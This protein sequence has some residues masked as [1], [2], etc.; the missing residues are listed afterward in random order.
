M[1]EKN[2]PATARRLREARRKGE[3]AR[4]ADVITTVQFIV[5]LALIAGVAP[6]GIGLLHGLM[7]V[8]QQVIAARDPDTRLAVLLVAVRHVLLLSVLSLSG[9]VLLAGVIAGIVQVGGIVAWARLTPQIS[10]LNPAAGL[11]RIVSMRALIDLAKA[12]GKTLAIGLILYAVIR[13]SI[14][15]AVEAGFTTPAQIF[16]LMGRLLSL[17]FG[18]A[19]VIYAIIAGLDF[20]HQR[21]EFARNHRMSTEEL[22]REHREMEGD[23]MVSSRRSQLAREAQ[24]ASMQDV[25]RGASVVIYS[26]RVAVA[27]HY[28]GEPTLPRVIAR[29][30][31]E[32]AE[33][34]RTIAQELLRPAV[35]NTGL[36]EKLY[37]NVP[38]GRYIDR[39]HF[40]EV[41][42]ALRWAGGGE[43]E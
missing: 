17:L 18:W 28:A 34:I 7:D 41:A 5:L 1:A 20:V 36:A 32:A 10:R 8:A 4:S 11:K 25:L 22:R 19:A 14:G 24:F 2:H 16:A 13:G 6:I 21:W 38:L 29:G 3:V 31:G 9:A 43:V 40:R 15:A 35:A 23:P 39:G 42:D 30:E 12:I 33:R 26:A 27:L 37:E